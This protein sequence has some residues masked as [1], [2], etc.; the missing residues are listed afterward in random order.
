MP[1]AIRAA[2]LFDGV[3]DEPLLDAVIV[4]DGERIA[5]VG[6]EAPDGLA[7]TDLGEATLLP[8]LID[9][10]VHLTFDGSLDPVGSLAQAPDEQVL[11]GMRKAAR[12]ALAAGITTVR[13]LG[14]RNY[15]SLLMRAETAADP[16]A[17][18]HIVAA[19]PPITTTKGH[20]WYLGGEADGVDGV[21]AAV[22]EHAARGVDVIKV[23]TSGGELT[24]G[25]HSHE[26]AYSAPELKAIA[27]EAHGLGLPV[28][29]HAHAAEAVATAIAAG[30]D[31]IEHCTFLAEEGLSDRP[32]V[33]EALARSGAVVSAT[34][35]IKPGATPVPR[36]AALLPL[37]MDHF[38]RVHALGVPIVVSTDAG[39]GPQKP[40]DI[41]PQAAEMFA[42]VLGTRPAEALRAVTSVPAKVCR[43]GDRKGRL[44]PGYDADILAVAGDPLTDITALQQVRAVYRLGRE[45]S[46]TAG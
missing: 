4:V 15:L 12:T 17:G 26:V 42:T 11:E 41:L 33:L 37:L 2:R 19:G 23:M 31:S 8:G 39:I 24:P 45:V 32:D 25:T 22:R 46:S 30:F 35:G 36:I 14:D 7:I 16:A 1:Y 43:L 3:G 10:H 5:A 21:R 28:A 29:G 27:E 20:C 44:A 9:V 40:F 13:D 38:R 6:H 18:P 34:L